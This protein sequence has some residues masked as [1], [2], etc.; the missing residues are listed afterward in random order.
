MAL[1][2]LFERKPLMLMLLLLLWPTNDEGKG[3]L[4]FCLRNLEQTDRSSKQTKTYNLHFLLFWF[5]HLYFRP[6]R[7][8]LSKNY[9]SMA[10][11]FETFLLRRQF[12]FFIFESRLGIKGEKLFD[13]NC[14]LMLLDRPHMV[15]GRWLSCFVISLSLSISRCRCLVID[16]S[17]S[18]SRYR[19]LVTVISLPLSRYRYLL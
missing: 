2:T 11:I 5:F 18:I 19:Y 1:S 15:C 14:F 9:F 13:R 7:Q 12:F 17:L 3:S 4:R 8:Y 10:T 6:L 16:I